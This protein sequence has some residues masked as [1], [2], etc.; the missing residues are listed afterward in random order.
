MGP[1]EKLQRE[2]I[3][4]YCTCWHLDCAVGYVVFSVYSVLF[5]QPNTMLII[6]KY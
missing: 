5:H 3:M 1:A 4:V 2:T 6:S